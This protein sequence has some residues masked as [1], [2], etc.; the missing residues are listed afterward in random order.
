MEG[1]GGA[2]GGEKVRGYE[3]TREGRREGPRVRA[4]EGKR[5]E[6]LMVVV[7]FY[8]VVAGRLNGITHS[9]RFRKKRSVKK[10]AVGPP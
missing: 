4:R 8:R 7:R 9:R 2:S 1:G 5:R 10:T 6:Q 3:R